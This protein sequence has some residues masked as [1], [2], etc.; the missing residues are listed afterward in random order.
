MTEYSV[1]DIVGPRMTGPSSSHTAGACRLGHIARHIAGAE[2]VCVKYTLYGSFAK[3]GAGHGTDK[4]LVAGVLGMLMDD[5]R[6]ADAFYHAEAAGLSWTFIKSEEE[7]AY[8]PNTARI[9][10]TDVEGNTTEVL[11]CSVGGG[12]I[13]VVEINGLEVEITGEYPTL[14]IQYRDAPGVVS[15]VTHVLAQHQI[16]IAFMRVFRHGKGADAYM[17]I[18]TDQPVGNR[19]KDLIVNLSTEIKRAFTV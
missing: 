17:T 12:N 14:I 5:P 7:A 9:E 11:G 13:L 1:F 2:A 6:I 8:H 3:T 18:E 19:L 15:V 10:I 16:N 4:A